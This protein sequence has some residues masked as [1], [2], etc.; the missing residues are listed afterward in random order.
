MTVSCDRAGQDHAITKEKDRAIRKEYEK[1]PVRVRL[2]LDRAAMTVAESLKL[3]LEIEAREEVSVEFPPLSKELGGFSIAD[4]REDLP[5][6]LTPGTI[7]HG[8][9][10]TLEPFLAGDYTIP[11]LRVG[12]RKKATG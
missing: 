10:Y 4:E 9:V 1:G 12:F 6:L 3:S 8:R 11:P 2:V 7:R 5:R